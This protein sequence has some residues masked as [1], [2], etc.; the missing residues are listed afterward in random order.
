MPRGHAGHGLTGQ[1]WTWAL[2]VVICVLIFYRS[3]GT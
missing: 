3:I 1:S 2:C